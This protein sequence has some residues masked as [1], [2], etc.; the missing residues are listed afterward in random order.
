MDAA[1][2]DYFD[3]MVGKIDGVSKEVKS[4]KDAQEKTNDKVI[5]IEKQLVKH[6]AYNKGLDVKAR[7]TKTEQELDKKASKIGLQWG[8]GVFVTVL[9]LAITA[10]AAFK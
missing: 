3:N 4:L 9:A 6:I 2:K 7:L 8:L 1:T 10:V 5:D